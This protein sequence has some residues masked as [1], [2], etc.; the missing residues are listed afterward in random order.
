MK[1]MVC[2]RKLK[3]GTPVLVVDLRKL[4]EALVC[5]VIIITIML[6]PSLL[7]E[8]GGVTM[9]II[10]IRD[11][12]DAYKDKQATQ[13][14][15]QGEMQ[16][17]YQDFY[18]IADYFNSLNCQVYTEKEIATN[19]YEYKSEYDYSMRKGK[20]TRTMIELCKLCCEDMDYLNYP[21]IQEENA[22]TVGQ[23]QEILSDFMMEMML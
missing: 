17:E 1:H 16:M 4:G 6:A 14:W 15:N 13:E 9:P 2:T 11:I 20:P 8:K 3:N 5:A 12:E 18:D 10:T 22:F 19:A 23:M 21:Q 7:Q